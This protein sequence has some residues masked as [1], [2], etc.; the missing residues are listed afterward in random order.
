MATGSCVR[1][2]EGGLERVVWF[3]GGWGKWEV[4]SGGV[5]LTF[6][7]RWQMPALRK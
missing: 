2:G 4:G 7:A 3:G 6:A 5:F 1:G